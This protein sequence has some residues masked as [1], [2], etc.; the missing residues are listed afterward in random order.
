MENSKQIV[1]IGGGITGLSAA[2]YLNTH[3]HQSFNVILIEAEKTLGGKMV[4][5]RVEIEDGEHL[6]IDGGVDSFMTRKPQVW[7][8]AEELDLRDEVINGG[9]ELDQLF[10]LRD[11]KP[12]KI[13][14]SFLGL[15]FSG[16]LTFNGKLRI[17]KE[18]FI[19]AKTDDEDESV[20]SFVTRRFGRE[21]LDK[22]AG[23]VLEGL[24]YGDPKVESMLAVHPE[25]VAMEKKHGSL[26]EGV[27]RWR[28]TNLFSSNLG[29]KNL[30]RIAFKQGVQTLINQMASKLKL[31][32]RTGTRALEV[33]KYEGRFQVVLSAG[34]PIVADGV[35]LATP[36]NV[37]SEILKYIA[38]E[39]AAMLFQIQHESRG[40]L[41]LAYRSEDVGWPTKFQ[42]LLIP[43]AEQLKIDVVEWTTTKSYSGTSGGYELLKVHFGSADEGLTD[44]SE[45]ELVKIIQGELKDILGIK[46]EP[47]HAEVFR[48]QNGFPRL[49]VGHLELVD[50]IEGQLPEGIFLAGSSYRGSDVPD[51]IQQGYD[52]AEICLQQM[53]RVE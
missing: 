49:D 17:F 14:K 33:N 42:K 35:I 39:S 10:M 1:I 5:H 27:L 31:E 16:L 34:D 12:V 3:S 2:W 36:A 48:W 44:L 20:A 40:A 7:M 41:S 30:K 37:S 11:G 51:C 26:L 15:L 23:P 9:S 38:P 25:L 13:P 29:R 19:P 43:R 4:T 32:I 28:L 53:E 50:L 22:I 6:V 8:L 24:G 18:L 52:A 47:V 45:A 21:F 46:A